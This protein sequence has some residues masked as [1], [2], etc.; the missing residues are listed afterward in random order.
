MRGQ[1]T[2]T[3][4][5]A[6]CQPLQIEHSAVAGTDPNN[7]HHCSGH[8]RLVGSA[9][10]RRLSGELNICCFFRTSALWVEVIGGLVWLVDRLGKIIN[11]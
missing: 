6:R 10:D 9:R 5:L 1:V 3:G 7:W 11:V 4:N 2:R 8:D